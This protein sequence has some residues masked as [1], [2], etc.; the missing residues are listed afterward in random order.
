MVKSPWMVS[1]VSDELRGGTV[2][3]ERWVLVVL[4]ALSALVTG[5]LSLAA[6][7]RRHSPLGYTFFFFT[8]LITLYIVG[9]MC[10]LAS[11][12]LGAIRFWLRVES[13]GIAFLPTLWIALAVYHTGSKIRHWPKILALLMMVSTITFIM[14]NTSEFH[15]LH[16]GPLRLNQEAPFPVVAFEPGPWYWVHIAFINLAVLVGNILY[17]RAW[18]RKPSDKSQQAFVLFLGSLFPWVVLIVYLLKLIPWGI[19][20][21]P[22]AFLVPGVLYS[23]ATF[24]L[25][26]LEIAPIAK[27][28]VFQKLS[29]GVLVFDRDGHLAEYNVAAATAFP[30]LTDAAKGKNSG[31]LFGEYAV[32]ASIFAGPTD[33]RL[34]MCLVAGGE[35][36]DYQLERIELYDGE[37]DVAGFMVVLRNITNFT[38]IMEG[39]RLQ[40]AIDPLTK[41][42]SRSRWQEDG[43]ALVAQARLKQGTIALILADLDEFKQVNDSRGHLAGDA[44]LEDFSLTCRKNLRAEDIFGR[45]GGDEFVIILPG[46]SREEAEALAERLRRAVASMAAGEGDIRVTASFGVVVDQTGSLGLDDLVRKADEALYAAKNAG[47]NRVCGV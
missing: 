15:H 22:V 21:L 16:Y 19:D 36:I 37:G 26:M 38:T 23:W 47:G 39:L 18:G 34:E 45:F 17:A 14:S 40:A 28:A 33:E 25:R 32:M 24:G 20:P 46:C 27:H 6:W 44:V 9:Y 41:A 2:S 13:A 11:D 35:K 7:R 42:W 4:I 31:A 12:T 8:F 43:K 1:A 29:D 30:Q 5:T 3:Y 10:E